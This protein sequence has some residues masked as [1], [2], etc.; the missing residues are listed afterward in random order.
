MAV[1]AVGAAAAAGLGGAE[2]PSAA[3]GAPVA[4]ALPDFHG[5]HQA[6]VFTPA[7][8]SAVF[9]AFDVTVSSAAALRDLL[10][11]LTDRA[12]ILTAGQAPPAALSVNDP[13]ADNGVL[14]PDLATDRL[15]VTVSVGASLFDDRY[16]LGDRKPVRLTAMP[17]FA[18]DALE[19]GWCHG[20]LMLQ[21]CADSMDTVHHAVRD[22]A[23]ATRGALQLRYR[24]PGFISQPRP[25][26]IPRNLMG[27]KDGI[28]NPKEVDGPR[29]V[30]VNGGQGEPA[31]ATG[32]T[33]Q[34]VRFIRMLTEFWD[35][36]SL[37]EQENIFG[38]RRDSGAPLD[39]TVETDIPDYAKDPAGALIPMDAHIRLANPR[40]DAT[41]ASR[42]L[43]R[44]YNYDAGALTNGT[45][46]AGLIFC[47]YQQDVARQFAVVQT[48]LADDPLNDYIRPFGGGYFFALPGVASTVDWY[49]RALLA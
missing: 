30:W 41:A 44:G 43:R 2:G 40:T 34:V 31:W 32:G 18:N 36:I 16:G 22:L 6:G 23:R 10:R 26:G 17:A 20:D 48:R 38:R 46:D 9:A 12:R 19:S 45:L 33:Y 8:R 25:A 42:I 47:C 27:F 7:Q 24:M 29:L 39:G 49:G 37:K 11:A 15:T 14:G 3:V 35:R 5:P 28:A 13:P 4:A 1:G 21:I